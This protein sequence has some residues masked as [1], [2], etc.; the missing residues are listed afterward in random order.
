MF[1][2][3]SL[4]TTDVGRTDPNSKLFEAAGYGELST[5]KQ[6]LDTVGVDINFPPPKVRGRTAL[7]AAAEGHVE[8]TQ[9]LLARGANVNAPSAE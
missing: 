8:L 6:L 1:T 5:V 3:A 9:L 4:A 2:S 7:Q